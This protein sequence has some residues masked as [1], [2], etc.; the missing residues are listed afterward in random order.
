MEQ[1]IRE[2]SD[3]MIKRLEAQRN[4]VRNHYVS[5]SNKNYNTFEGK[6]GLIDVILKSNWINRD[7]TN[8]LQCLGVSLGDAIVQDLGFRWIE[9]EDLYGIDP[10]LKFRD[11]SLIL[12]PLT[13]IS[14]RIENNEVVDIHEL[15][16]KIK[17][18]VVELID[19]KGK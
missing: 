18:K 7:E 12:Y 14:K 8:K 9:I 4:W 6:L 17:D 19:L 3:E 1:V 2:L 16:D 11:T 13:M 15:Y 10:A 5:D